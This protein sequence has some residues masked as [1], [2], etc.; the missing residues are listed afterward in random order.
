LAFIA[1]VS[2]GSISYVKRSD[3]VGSYGYGGELSGG[4]SSGL[5]G[6]AGAGIGGAAGNY[7]GD[8]QDYYHYPKYKF[9]YGVKDPI[10]HDHKSQWEI[11][12]GDVVKGEYTLDESDGTTRVVSYEASDKTG[13]NA[14]VKKIGHA[15]H[16]GAFGGQ[17]GGFG[18]Q[19]QGQQGG[20]GG[21]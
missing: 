21:F 20:F 6:G 19:Q 13:F 4:F 10:T 18:G 11:R 14:I 16:S 3:G 2:A 5:G 1:A 12:D 9:E 8:F 17:Q 15:H 7:A